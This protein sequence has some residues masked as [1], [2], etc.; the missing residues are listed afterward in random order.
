M[1]APGASALTAAKTWPI[2]ACLLWLG[3]AA[4]PRG[5][6]P[7]P[8]AAGVLLYA[9]PGL[10]DPNFEKTVVLLIE[11]NAQGSLGLVI[12]RP[13]DLGLETV[14]DLEENPLG[15]DVPVYWGGPVQPS[16]VMVLLRSARPDLR[17]RT[18]VRDVQLVQDL[19]E[20][21][22]MLAQRD[23]RL[24]VRVFSG[25]AGWDKGQLADEMR[26]GS[27]VLDR[28]D[29]ATVFT[30]EPS[31]LWQRVHEIRTRLQA[32]ALWPPRPPRRLPG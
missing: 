7:Q 28:A 5:D 19:S 16:A 8:L 20:V 22:D 26:R 29:A 23:A 4:A 30:P 25:Y 13:T 1:L 24:R 27:W 17:T 15:L 2:V 21:R 32:W 10:P 11:H 31:R 12:N 9:M 14:L 3:I 6:R 18:I